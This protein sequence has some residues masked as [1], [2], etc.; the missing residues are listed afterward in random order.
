LS[1]DAL[2]FARHYAPL[3]SERE[4]ENVRSR[5]SRAMIEEQMVVNGALVAKVAPAGRDAGSELIPL[6]VN[7]SQKR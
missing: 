2:T 5:K 7:I 4:T 1:L 3:A 6:I